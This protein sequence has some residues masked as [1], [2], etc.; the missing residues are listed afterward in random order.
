[1]NLKEQVEKCQSCSLRKKINGELIPN[2]GV[3]SSNPK[4]MIIIDN[5]KDNNL[6]DGIILEYLNKNLSKYDIQKSDLYITPLVKCPSKYN[7]SEFKE[8]SKWIDIEYN[9]F[10]PKMVIYLTSHKI[11]KDFSPISNSI[12]YNIS[13]HKLAT[14]SATDRKYSEKI[15]KTIK[16][17]IND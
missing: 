14:N 10:K 17:T 4:I 9:H 12:I 5:S 11:D 16:E 3:G 2:F 1:M 6:I 13:L 15:F 8:C 7:K